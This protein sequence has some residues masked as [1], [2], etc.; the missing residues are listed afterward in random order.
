M[1]F[2]LDALRSAISR[3]QSSSPTSLTAETGTG[4][5][6]SISSDQ[7]RQQSSVAF[8]PIR[9]INTENNSHASTPFSGRDT[10]VKR[11]LKSAFSLLIT[12]IIKRIFS[13]KF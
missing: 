13:K 9:E 8:V 7:Q 6:S 4:T 11:W 12:L 10:V 2:S 5:S 3:R 1:F